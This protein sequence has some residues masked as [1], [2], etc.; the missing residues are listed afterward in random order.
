M[1]GTWWVPHL[2]KATS[3]HRRQLCYTISTVFRERH[4]KTRRFLSAR[5]SCAR[6]H[7]RC[8]ANAVIQR[9]RMLQILKSQRCSFV[10]FEKRHVLKVEGIT[11]CGKLYVRVQQTR[12]EEKSN[13][14]F[15]SLNIWI[16][17]RRISCSVP[18]TGT[19]SAAD[20]VGWK[21]RQRHL[22]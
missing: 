9:R 4:A 8:L 1:T 3:Q 6:Q 19:A 2:K 12:I 14:R 17:F 11:L 15:S 20:I 5:S 18:C 22:L 21:T 7:H 13:R 16:L 10:M